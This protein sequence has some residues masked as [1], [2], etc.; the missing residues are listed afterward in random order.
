LDL[1]EREPVKQ[2]REDLATPI[3]PPTWAAR[4]DWRPIA[5]QPATERVASFADF[6]DRELARLRFTKWLIET[7]RL[8]P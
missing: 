1:S 7:G 2:D 3:P 6:T 5:P 4:R 8:I